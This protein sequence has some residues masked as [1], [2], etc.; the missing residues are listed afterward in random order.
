[1]T[2][3]FKDASDF[4]GRTVN[5]NLTNQVVN[6]DKLAGVADI[7]VS[8]HANA[9][10]GVATGAEVW[11]YAGDSIGKQ[12]AEKTSAAIAKA[13]GIVNRGAKPTT[14]LYVVSQSVGHTILIEWFF[15]DNASDVAKWK[16]NKGA[17]IAAVMKVFESYP[18]YNFK[19]THGG[20]YGY[21]LMDPGAVGNGLKEAVVM[22][23]VNQAI[24]NY[25]NTGTTN[26]PQKDLDYKPTQM[27]GIKTYWYVWDSPY[28]VDLRKFLKANNFS[29]TE[30][31]SSP[32]IGLEIKWFNQNSPNKRKVMDY[33]EARG[34]NYE[35]IMEPKK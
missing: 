34:F 14:N 23:E 10:N 17:A 7:N 28:L 4:S 20:H 13:L 21:N 11:Y 1:M 27:H 32:W 9:F 15:I 33:L 30:F 16:A 2:L 18:Q 35:I 31:K 3:A 24:L 29:Y 25:K 6:M 19:S 12:L 26:P 8:N 5:Q 22:Q